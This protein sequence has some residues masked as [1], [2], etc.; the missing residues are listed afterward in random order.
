[1]EPEELFH[2]EQGPESFSLTMMP[3][4]S[5]SEPTPETVVFKKR[6][7]EFHVVYVSDKLWTSDRILLEDTEKSGV[8]QP[9][10]TT[11][12][13]ESLKNV[14]LSLCYVLQRDRQSGWWIMWL[15]VMSSKGDSESGEEVE[16]TLL[17]PQSKTKAAFW[18][19][20]MHSYVLSDWDL[21]LGD[22]DSTYSWVSHANIITELDN[23]KMTE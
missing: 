2:L 20:G 19:E 3:I 4:K 15:A 9:V 5:E 16:L 11:L 22:S 7:E 21:C 17:F 10:L 13:I 1:M 8:L 6:R 18:M 12:G 23:V 14:A